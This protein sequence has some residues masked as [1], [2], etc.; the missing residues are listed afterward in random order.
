MSLLVYGPVG[1]GR[2]TGQL[3]IGSGVAFDVGA[4]LVSGGGSIT[5]DTVAS[6]GLAAALAEFPGL[7]LVGNI[8]G[9]PDTPE[10]E[11]NRA[12]FA[13]MVTYGHSIPAGGGASTSD[14]R[15]PSILAGLLGLPDDG[16]YAV[17]GAYVARDSVTGAN[18]GVSYIA[19]REKRTITKAPYTSNRDLVVLNFGYEDITLGLTN[20]SGTPVAQNSFIFTN[21]LQSALS[22]VRSSSRKYA[23]DKTTNLDSSITLATPGNWTIVA[24]PA[25]LAG[26]RI[27]PGYCG[28]VGFIGTNTNGS[29]G[30]FGIAVPGDYPGSAAC[31]LYVM[32]VCTPGLTGGVVTASGAATGSLNLV[33]PIAAGTP[34]NTPGTYDAVNGW[35]NLIVMR[36]TG[37][38]IAP[39]EG[40]PQ[41]LTLTPSSLATSGTVALGLAEWGIEASNPPTVVIPLLE[42]L[43]NPGVLV[44][45]GMR[46]SDIATFNGAIQNLVAN[47][48]DDGTVLTP[49]Y[50]LGQSGNTYGLNGNAGNTVAAVVV[51]STGFGGTSS[52]NCQVTA[53]HWPTAGV[54]MINGGE[55]II[56]TSATVA[57]GVWTLGGVI[58]GAW[59]TIAS[60]HSGN[61]LIDTLNTA[62]ISNLSADGTHPSDQGH[63]LI[64]QAILQAVATQ[65]LATVS[66][67]QTAKRK[68]RIY[69]IYQNSQYQQ[70]VGPQGT[71]FGEV[72][73]ILYW[74]QTLVDTVSMHQDT[75]SI[76]GDPS[77]WYIP[78]DG[79]YSVS[80]FLNWSIG[81]ATNALSGTAIGG[82]VGV[83]LFKNGTYESEDVKVMGTDTSDFPN[84]FWTL[85]HSVTFEDVECRNGDQL[86]LKAW[87]NTAG[88]A[89]T[90][91]AAMT[92]TTSTAASVTSSTGM[93]VNDVLRVDNEQMLITNISGGNL[94]LTRGYNGTTAATHLNAAPAFTGR[95]ILGAAS[96]AKPS[97]IVVKRTMVV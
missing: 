61:P 87:Q 6:P 41:T 76:F 44:F 24:N 64:A 16:N 5:V 27:P 96:S 59:N 79:L 62:A 49:S 43:G 50:S 93:A 40:V 39:S 21:G 4:A 13:N 81:K 15:Y 14:A 82:V 80:V 57:S 11:T 18:A 8:P 23:G 70:I 56:W 73:Q 46:D 34:T 10:F 77:I 91:S 54:A 71:G 53:V 1:V 3:N 85:P 83:Y 30:A 89:T 67:S 92:T 2:V 68:A 86:Q 35:A 78:A 66:R 36:F 48:F 74:D 25:A 45:Q 63:G 19:L 32:F 20:T 33:Q 22:L 47:S 7:I 17:G 58:R 42:R 38:S 37:S 29:G 95:A 52:V 9:M 94:T 72:V 55:I 31:P 65:S 88:V 26:Q 90:L 12:V 75:L 69:G 97:K 84:A 51:S 60:G 28:S